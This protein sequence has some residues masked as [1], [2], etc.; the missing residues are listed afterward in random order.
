MKGPKSLSKERVSLF[1]ASRL[2]YEC[3]LWCSVH[4]SAQMSDVTSL[5]QF[6]VL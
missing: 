2:R 1:G 3:L 5:I 4:W 6:L